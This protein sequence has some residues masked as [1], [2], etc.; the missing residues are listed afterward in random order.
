MITEEELFRVNEINKNLHFIDNILKIEISRVSTFE[1]SLIGGFENYDLPSDMIKPF[2]DNIKKFLESY[3][4][5]LITEYNKIIY[6]N[7]TQNDKQ[8]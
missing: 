3:R 8:S 7:E 5:N 1:I 2:N 6:Q 4:D